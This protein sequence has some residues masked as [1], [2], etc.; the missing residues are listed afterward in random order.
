MRYELAVAFKYL[1][2]RKRQLSASVIA[3]LSVL[4]ISLVVWLVVVFLSV[5]DGL[6]KTWV[7][8]LVALNAPMRLTP[9]EA[10]YDSYYYR[11]DTISAASDYLEKSL[12]EKR[13]SLLSDPYDPFIDPQLPDYWPEADLHQDGSFKDIVKETFQALQS[14]AKRFSSTTHV[15]ASEY[16]TAFSTLRLRVQQAPSPA[17]LISQFSMLSSVAGETT[18]LAQTLLHPSPEDLN[19]LLEMLTLSPEEVRKEA[20]SHE[21]LLPPQQFQERARR[22]FA[23]AT[24]SHLCATSTDW[25]IPHRLLPDL[26]TFEVLVLHNAFPRPA[27]KLITSSTEKELYQAYNAF[28]AEGYRVE[29]GTLTLHSQS[30]TLT[31]KEIPSLL[32]PRSTPLFLR[33]PPL[34]NA[35]FLETSLPDAASLDDLLFDVAFSIQDTLISGTISYGD[36]VQIAKM[37][38]E[39]LFSTLPEIEPLWA[40]EVVESQG[41]RSLHLPEDTYVGHGVL[42]AKDFQQGGA[43]LGDRGY[44]GYFGPQLSSL[45]EQRLPIYVAGFY[46]PGIM[47]V[48]HKVILVAPSVTRSIRLSHESI[49][50]SFANGIA[51]RFSDLS[52]TSKIQEALQKS[53]EAQ[54]L[55]HYWKLETYRD[56]DFSKA[57]VHQL[58]SDKNLFTLVSLIIILVACS[59]II[60]MLILLVKDKK[61]EI[62]ILRSMGASSWSLAIIFGIC[63]LSMGLLSCLLG[64][65]A[66]LFTLSHLQ[67]L[68]DLLTTLQGHAAFETAFYGDSLPNQI[69]SS[70]LAV[71]IFATL[72]LSLFA[73]LIPAIKASR[74]KPAA[75][76][77][78][79]G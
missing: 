1:I 43:Q 36:H 59:N 38:V 37:D 78:M 73:G 13:Y 39:H 75:I 22:F 42:L 29:I 14:V 45:Q 15:T 68:L 32:L 31:S 71:V 74:M 51:I 23:H 63:G 11:V 41:H 62:G 44:L 17:R 4:V 21:L 49:D 69:S 64:C 12:G 5:M 52:Q 10:Y 79:E 53:L 28:K 61:R 34:M 50:P 8:R 18:T 54:G 47:P 19:H 58:Q 3:L 70:A 57:L 25:Q 40:Y 76:L 65:G 66:A 72:A 30:M 35:K 20:P 16:E 60:S 67:S 27:I 77:R 9:K 24:P 55:A 7:E 2:P 46:D 48:G 26:G 33:S 56:Y 6:E